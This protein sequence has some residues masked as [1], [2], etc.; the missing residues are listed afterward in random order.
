MISFNGQH[1]GPGICNC[2]IVKCDEFPG[3]L[4][5]QEWLAQRMKEFESEETTN[6]SMV[7]IFG[8]PGA[9]AV[10]VQKVKDSIVINFVES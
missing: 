7:S 6:R 10:S 4:G 1:I 3:V 8:P 5:V 9:N 2:G